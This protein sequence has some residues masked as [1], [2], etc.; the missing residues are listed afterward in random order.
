[1]A[2]V[3]EGVD[4]LLRVQH[5]QEY[6]AILE[7][8][9]P[10]DYA[11]QQNDYITKRQE[12]T[13]KWLLNSSEFQDWV[14]Q[15][16]STLFC[17]GIPGAGKTIL[18]SI[19]VDHL[20]AKFRNDSRIGIAYIY[21]SYQPQ[22]EQKVEDLLSCLLKQ[23]ARKRPAV[24]PDVQD[25]YCHHKTK[26]TRPSFDEVVR[27][28]HST[29]QLYSKVFIII[30]ALDEYYASSNE[31]QKR[32]LS[33]V[34]SLQDNTQLSL[35]ATSRFVAEITSQFKGCISKEIRAQDDD[36]LRY[37]NG[38]MHQLLRSTISKHL[39]VQ[40]TIRRDIVKAA[41]GMYAH[42]LSAYLLN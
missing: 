33:E 5:D 28:L 3:Q 18:S 29:I 22:Q 31:A 4:K 9:T 10:T 6:K 40:D 24:P 38:R 35:F 39:N 30:D 1:M 25:L 15:S 23:L 37:V 20:N 32:L 21:C 36:I 14:Y 42:P 11:H 12:G 7:W 27:A 16:K 17:P 34:F 19:V 2:G 26:G 13:G 41:D 8:L